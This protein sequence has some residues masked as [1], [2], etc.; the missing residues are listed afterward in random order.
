MIGV[1]AGAS[2]GFDVPLIVM[3]NMR[4]QGAAVGSRAMFE[5]MARGLERF[6]ARP[7]LDDARYGF[8]DLPAALAALGRGGHLGETVLDF[9]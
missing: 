4:L 7:P 3:Q 1:L 2:C 9:Q 6:Q 5:D 8:K